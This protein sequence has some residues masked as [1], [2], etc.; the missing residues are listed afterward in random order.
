MSMRS[1]VLNAFVDVGHCKMI[2]WLCFVSG[3]DWLLVVQKGHCDNSPS[4]PWKNNTFVHLDYQ[5]SSMW[6]GFK[7]SPHKLTLEEFGRFCIDVLF[8]DL[9]FCMVNVLISYG[10][11]MLVEQKSWNNFCRG[12]ELLNSGLKSIQHTNHS[13]SVFCINLNVLIVFCFWF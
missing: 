1:S 9:F 6:D 12:W 8:L 11:G 7:S 2:D 10:V 4:G 13:F 3:A 5:H